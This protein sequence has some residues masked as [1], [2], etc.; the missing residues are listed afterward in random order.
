MGNLKI[1]CFF[2]KGSYA[3]ENKKHI[4]KEGQ[5]S[6]GRKVVQQ[7]KTRRYLEVLL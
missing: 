3:K 4:L 7:R 6:I 1:E 5:L 2:E